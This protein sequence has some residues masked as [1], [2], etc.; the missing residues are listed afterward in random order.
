MEM[1]ADEQMASLGIMLCCACS[2]IEGLVGADRTCRHIWGHGCDNSFPPF[3]QVICAAQS[4]PPAADSD[5]AIATRI[6]AIRCVCTIWYR[7][8]S[9]IADLA[10]VP[11]DDQDDSGPP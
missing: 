8:I 5:A 7:S 11:Q 6:A 9:H 2:F 4:R 3:L 10:D 1:L